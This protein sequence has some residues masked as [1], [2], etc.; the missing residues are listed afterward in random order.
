MKRYKVTGIINFQG[1]PVEEVVTASNPKE[2]ERAF[3]KLYITE[4]VL[5]LTCTKT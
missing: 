3:R 1:D 5:I 2:A 4:P